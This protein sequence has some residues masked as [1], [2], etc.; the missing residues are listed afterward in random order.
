MTET[1][2]YTI[3]AGTVQEIRIRRSLFRGTL[4]PAQT[5][6]DA[7]AQIARLREQYHDATHNCFG[8]RIDDDTY[9]FS[10]DGEPSGTAGKPILAM[11]EKYHLY[12]CL[13]VV[14]RYFGGVKLGTGGL[15]RAYSQCAEATI[16]KAKLKKFVQYQRW[17]IQYP[18]NLTRKIHYLVSKYNGVI[19]HSDFHAAV[20]SSVRIPTEAVTPFEA[21]L[22]QSG[23]GQIHMIFIESGKNTSSEGSQ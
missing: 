3:D 8:Y 6:D 19:D 21:E 16:Q 4:S 1:E 12:R 20:T 2:R 10:D 22:T 9:R 23:A 13:L 11:L 7:E 17:N 15:I 18:Y 14:T 5:R